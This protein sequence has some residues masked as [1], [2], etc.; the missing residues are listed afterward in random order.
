MLLQDFDFKVEHRAVAENGNADCLSRFP[1]DSMG[2][3]EVPHWKRGD[4]TFRHET[5][6]AMMALGVGEQEKVDETTE[7]TSGEVWADKHLLEYL[8]AGKHSEE[9]DALERDRVY[10]RG[11]KYRWLGTSLYKVGEKEMS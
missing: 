5:L 4:I 3:P 8:Q 7:A 9:W 6:L 1:I 2:G 11:T 10:R